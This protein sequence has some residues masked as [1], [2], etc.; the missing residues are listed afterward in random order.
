[1]GVLTPGPDGYDAERTLKKRQLALILDALTERG[2]N[3]PCPRCGNEEFIVERGLIS[4]SL[5]ISVEEATLG[6]L[7]I[8]VAVTSCVRCG[9]LA[10]HAL[11]A[12]GLLNHPAFA[13]SKEDEG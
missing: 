4:H 2:V 10:E 1:L 6:G 9:F 8:P 13:A 5:Q 12:L 11:G 3:R 7:G